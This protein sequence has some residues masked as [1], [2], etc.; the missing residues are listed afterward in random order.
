MRTLLTAALVS[1]LIVAGCSDDGESA[2]EAADRLAASLASGKLAA[3]L[4]EDGSDQSSAQASYDQIT[5][6]LGS[7]SPEVEVEEV[8]EEDGEA[9]VTLGWSWAVEG[10]RWSYAS[11]TTLTESGAGWRATWRPEVVEPSLAEGES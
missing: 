4:F 7:S 10:A 11:T 1:T 6:A 9:A 3:D 5:D 8:G 2:E